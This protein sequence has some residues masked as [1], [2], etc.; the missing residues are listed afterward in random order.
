VDRRSTAVIGGTPMRSTRLS[1][2]ASV[3]GAAPAVGPR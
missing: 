2:P 3:V 1:E